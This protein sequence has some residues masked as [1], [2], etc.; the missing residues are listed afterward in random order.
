MICTYHIYIYVFKKTKKIF[1]LKE[2]IILIHDDIDLTTHLS[3]LLKTSQ[4]MQ[5]LAKIW[6]L[7]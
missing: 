4:E 7:H 2:K 1:F 3:E 6:E 5:K